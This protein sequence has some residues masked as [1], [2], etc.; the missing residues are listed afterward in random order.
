MSSGESV[1]TDLSLLTCSTGAGRPITGFPPRR[2]PAS[3]TSGSPGKVQPGTPDTASSGAMDI[4]GKNAGATRVIV[5]RPDV[6][7]TSEEWSMLR[8]C[9]KTRGIHG[10]K[11]AASIPDVEH[12][13]WQRDGGAS[14]LCRRSQSVQLGMIRGESAANSQ[15]SEKRKVRAKLN[16]STTMLRFRQQSSHASEVAFSRQVGRRIRATVFALECMTG[17]G[18]STD[19]VVDVD[20]DVGLYTG[21]DYA[22]IARY[23][24]NIRVAPQLSRVIQENIRARMGKRRIR[25]ITVADVRSL[26][27]ACAEL[28]R[29]QR[30]LMIFN[31]LQ[32]V[33]AADFTALPEP[34]IVELETVPPRVRDY[35]PRSPTQLGGLSRVSTT[36]EASEDSRDIDIDFSNCQTAGSQ[37]DGSQLEE[38]ESLPSRR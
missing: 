36:T 35:P 33:D 28:G 17:Y 22:R 1:D 31:W 25:P 13:G 38:K 19:V 10:K 8:V 14:K 12:D 34:T 3:K 18:D 32:E 20:G 16:R 27:S 23:P 7:V 15:A 5:F 21:A 24:Q 2:V 30:N 9:T 26:D 6:V 29:Y 11:K 4:H 37:E